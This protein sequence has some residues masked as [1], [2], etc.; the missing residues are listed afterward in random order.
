VVTEVR[1]GWVRVQ[2]PVRP[3]GSEGWVRAEDVT[4]SEI[5]TLVEVSVSGRTLRAHRDG[6]VV[7]ESPVVVGEAD[8]PT[9]TGR[10]F[11]TDEVAKPPTGAY[12]PWILAVSA[13][14]QTM[15]TFADGAP[16]IAIHGTK[17]PALMGSAASNGCVR[18][19]NDVIVALRD[20][21]PL[22]TP[23]DIRP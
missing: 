3:N 22:G 12:G 15:D 8:T 23:V 9:P 1:P 16:L 20:L 14:S 17:Y 5:D 21:L 18:V 4:L 10:F 7:I 11:L 19:P 2:V 13:F 6:Q